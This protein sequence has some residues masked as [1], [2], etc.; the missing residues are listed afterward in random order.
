MKNLLTICAALLLGFTAFSQEI[1]KYSFAE[2]E[3]RLHPE[4]DVVYVFNFW[5]TWCK[6]C[7]EEL[8]HFEELTKAYEGKKVKVILVSLD[9][10]SQYKS[11]LL[12]FVKA[13]N[14][15]S[16]VVML[17]DSKYNEWIDKVSPEWGGAIPA[18]LVIHAGTNT[19]T[20]YN[21][22]F[23]TYEE[24]ENIIKPVLNKIP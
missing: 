2:L 10:A 4:D 11:K 14:L 7:V 1:P 24:L 21:K 8:P 18:T 20:F 17:N 13:H 16:E 9:F 6:P 22:K 23:A 15:Q 5:A 12:P 19:R 3:K